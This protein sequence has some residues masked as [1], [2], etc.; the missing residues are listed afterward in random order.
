MSLKIWSYFQDEGHLDPNFKIFILTIRR[1]WLL[2]Q[3]FCR[4]I[5]IHTLILTE[6]QNERMS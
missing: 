6:V 3:F 4:Y 5:C 1:K 2:F